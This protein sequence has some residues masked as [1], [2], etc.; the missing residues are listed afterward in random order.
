MK[1]LT[2]PIPTLFLALILGIAASGCSSNETSPTQGQEHEN[3]SGQS[4]EASADASHN[5]QAETDAG[6]NHQGESNGEGLHSEAL[7]Q[8]KANL[9]ENEV[10]ITER[11]M[12]GAGI[13]LGAITRQQLSKVV[14]SFGEIALAPSDEATVSALIGGII[15]NIRVI[16]GDFVRRG[17]VIARIVHPDIVDMQENYLDTR[18]QDE[19]LKV[20][21]Q[22]Q[23]RL[24]E[25]SINAKKTVQNARAAYQSNLAR[26]QS[27][28][29]KLQ[30][31]HIDPE[32]LNPENIRNGYP[33]KAPISGHVAEVEIN[34]GSHITPQQPL[35]HITANEKA[36]IDLKVYEQDLSKVAPGQPLTFNLANSPVSQ[37]MEGEVMKTAKRFDSN[38]RTALVHARIKDMKDMLLPGMSVVA[39]IQTG[40]KNQNT[41]P[42][43]AFVLDQGKDYVFRLK[44][45]GELNNQHDD[46]KKEHAHQEQEASQGEKAHHEHTTKE[47]PSDQSGYAAHEHHTNEQGEDISFFVFEKVMVDK[48]ITQGGFTSFTIEK[49][50][51]HSARF[52]IS[53]AQALLSEM[54][55]GGGGHSGHAH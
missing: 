51:F 28:K 39:Y 17:Q 30:L 36:H 13:E 26:L 42:E 8:A 19:Y 3:H 48:G 29:K 21:Y 46:G 4:H 27:L 41:L 14:K 34:T 20:E 45:K 1:T 22:R 6:H 16:E 15:R 11:Q 44:R 24:L 2:T 40:D 43:G 54:K 32:N 7:H 12:E 18:N 37:P 52:V 33:V 49:Q 5:H 25:D 50:N 38:E 55:K 9:S 35:F 23:K 10:L 31:I 53:N 47:P